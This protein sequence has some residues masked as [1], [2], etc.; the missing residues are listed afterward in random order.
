MAFALGEDGDQHVG[1]GD[2]LAAG[3]LHVDHRALD[4]ALEPGGRLG[5]VG[6]V[7]HQAF[8]LG[9]DVRHQIA[10]KLV[11]V[12][13]A[14]PHDRGGVL[15]V[16]QRQQQVLERRV[17]MVPLIGK[18]QR[19]VERLLEAAGKSGHYGLFISA[20]VISSPSRIAADAG[21]CGRSP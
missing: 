16:D 13:V 8:Q 7:R 21:A 11:E 5:I 18:R 4:D 6:T 14:G 1:A 15:I 9:F 2:L 10:A 20:T 17:F 19:P 12:D 3:R